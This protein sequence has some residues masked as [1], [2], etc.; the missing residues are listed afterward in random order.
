MQGGIET[1]ADALDQ[2][3]GQEATKYEPGRYLRLDGT[4]SMRGL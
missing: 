1:E 4:V 2:R 3:H